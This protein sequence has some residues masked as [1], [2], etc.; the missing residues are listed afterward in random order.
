MPYGVQVTTVKRDAV[1]D[2]YVYLVCDVQSDPVETR[3]SKSVGF[4][5]GLKQFLITCKA[6]ISAYVPANE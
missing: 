5:F 2:I 1:G 4:D 3:T 6:G